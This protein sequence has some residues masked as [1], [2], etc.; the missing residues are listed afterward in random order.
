MI[1]RALLA[2][3]SGAAA[4]ELA[5]MLPLLLVLLFGGMEGGHFIWT[6]HKLTEAV[7]DGARFAARLPVESYCV[8]GAPVTGA[9]TVADIK[10]VTR[11]GQLAPG[12]VVAVPGW[13]E[14]EVAVEVACGAFVDT[15]IYDDLDSAAPIVTVR[16]HSVAY[17]SL[18]G[19]MGA[20]DP[21][22]TMTARSS[23]PVIGL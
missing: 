17:P 5:L 19:R 4:A 8:G 22:I 15:G 12:G 7:R 6:Q 18:F 1:P 23:T 10:R 21:D 3:G 20:I 2:D 14:D 16:A 13:S 9:A 11:T